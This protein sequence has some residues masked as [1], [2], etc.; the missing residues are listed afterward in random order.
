[1]PTRFSPPPSPMVPQLTGQL[2][3]QLL[4]CRRPRRT[5]WTEPPLLQ[6]PSSISARRGGLVYQHRATWWVT[7]GPRVSFPGA[8]GVDRH[9]QTKRRFGTLATVSARIRHLTARV[10]VTGSTRACLRAS[11]R[12]HLCVYSRIVLGRASVHVRLYVHANN[13]N[14]ACG[15]TCT[16]CNER[17]LVGAASATAAAAAVAAAVGASLYS[18]QNTE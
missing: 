17:V 13:N 4:R 12:T 15:R 5:S 10:S 14:Y 1:M 3:R 6:T 7:A 11:T 16:C 8:F 9:R 2:L 18:M